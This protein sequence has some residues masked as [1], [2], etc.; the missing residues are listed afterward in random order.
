MGRV[1]SFP[2]AGFILGLLFS[3]GEREMTCSFETSVDFYWTTQHYI[4][5]ETALYNHHCENL[6]SYRVH[7]DFI[8]SLEVVNSGVLP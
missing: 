7:H 8:Q 4:P 6:K 3:D 2:N 1:T 5:E